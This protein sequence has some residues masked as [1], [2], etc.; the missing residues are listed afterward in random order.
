MPEGLTIGGV[1][2]RVVLNSWTEAPMVYQGARMTMAEGNI[3]STEY[4][5]TRICD[6]QA[7]FLTGAEE[8]ALRAVCPRG[9]PVT[10]AGE[11][12][13]TGFEGLVDIGQATKK[14][15]II[16][17][18]GETLVRVVALHIEEAAPA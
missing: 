5:G 2:V 13:E 15:A 8:A 9:V 12:P 7:Y 17:A 3:V 18:I 1:A 11:L 10:V 4:G 14:K 16:P 6:C